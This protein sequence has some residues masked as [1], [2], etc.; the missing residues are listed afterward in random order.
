MQTSARRACLGALATAAVLTAFAQPAHATESDASPE[1]GVL[2]S[3]ADDSN[4]MS[5]EACKYPSGSKFKFSLY[6]N[7]NLKGQYR[8]IGYSAYDFNAIRIGGSD[9]GAHALKFC[10]SMGPGAGLKVKNA[11]ASAQNRHG[12]YKA[13]VHFNSG[14]KGARDR[15]NPG[16]SMFKLK[17]TYNQNASFKFSS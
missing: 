5:M 17:K 14:Y 2:R 11:A 13:D 3:S 8:N 12:K 15:M 1:G 16:N 9:P 10:G 6:F 4:V 7:S